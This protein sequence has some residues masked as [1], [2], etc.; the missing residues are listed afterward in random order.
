MRTLMTLVLLFLIVTASFGQIK[1]EKGYLIT[2]QGERVEC[3]IKN[4]DWKNN[5]SEF[6]YK[7]SDSSTPQEG[8][9][10]SVKEF[11][12]YN[13]SK[14][15]GAD[16]EIDRSSAQ[17]TGLVGNAE[18]LWS[19]ERLFLRVLL[20]GKAKLY[21]Y[22]N[23]GGRKFFYSMT[24]TAIYQLV[25]KKFR[26]NFLAKNTMGQELSPIAEN[27]TYKDQLL[28][29]LKCSTGKLESVDNL[30]YITE[31]LERYF[32]SY[33]RC[34]GDTINEMN[35]QTKKSYFNL[36]ITPG[37]NSSSVSMP[38]ANRLLAYEFKRTEGFSLGLQFE[39]VIPYHKNKWAIVFEPTF[40]YL[41]SEAENGITNI[42]LRAI[43][44]PM[45]L[46]YYF[47]L[48]D[49]T[50]FYLNGF[51]NS[52]FAINFKSRIEL[53]PNMN[54]GI[55]PSGNWAFGGGIEHKRFSFETRYYTE[56]NLKPLENIDAL[57]SSFAILLGYKIIKAKH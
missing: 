3:L 55:S 6:N 5:P 12:I 9:L 31:D 4:K 2:S 51:Y 34:M 48:N 45:G 25:Y 10:T 21:S 29:N 20:D 35:K 13:Y 41:N 11:G 14:F 19:Q 7:L 50:R 15:I 33:N 38:L 17:A 43:E 1:Y 46:R 18:P 40:Q 49:H 16:V 42:K 8:N 24:D 47:N 27:S 44:F 52:N 22:D 54:F 23:S 37:I 56:R 30:T 26:I 39:M 32:R 28:E 57:Y 36:K 53:Y